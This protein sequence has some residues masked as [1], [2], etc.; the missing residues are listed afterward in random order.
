MQTPVTQFC[1]ILMLSVNYLP[2]IYKYRAQIKCFY[3]RD[4][5]VHTGFLGIRAPYNPISIPGILM[6]ESLY[7]PDLEATLCPPE[8][9]LRERGCGVSE[10]LTTHR[11]VVYEGVC[12]LCFLADRF[13][14]FKITFFPLDKGSFFFI[15]DGSSKLFKIK[16]NPA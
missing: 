10:G 9:A 3:A 8:L 16:K 6:E 13:L 5:I 12:V 1:Y 15:S 11:A 7:V 14:P 2:V 4:C